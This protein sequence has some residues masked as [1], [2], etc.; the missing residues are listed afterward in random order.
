MHP[1]VEVL[2]KQVDAVHISAALTLRERQAMNI[3]ISNAMKTN[4]VGHVEI[5]WRH[6]MPMRELLARLGENTRN[7]SRTRAT[8]D[9]LVD[10]KIQWAYT[11][12]RSKHH[13]GNTSLLAGYAIDD[14]QLSYS[15]SAVLVDRL[16]QPEVF[17]R[18]NMG[19]QSLFTHFHSLALYENCARYRDLGH[20]AWWS[21]EQFRGL[22]GVGHRTA[23][24][25]FK[26]LNRWVIKPATEDCNRNS[27][28]RVEPEFRRQGRAVVA[29]RFA[30][31]D[32][33]EYTGPRFPS[34]KRLDKLVDDSVVETDPDLFEHLLG[35]G[36]DHSRAADLMSRFDHERIRGNL[37]VV[38]DRYQRSP[39]KITNLASYTVSAIVNDYRPAQVCQQ[40][41]LAFAAQ[42][43]PESQEDPVETAKR[44][45]RDCLLDFESRD[46]PAYLVDQWQASQSSKTLAVERENFYDEVL[47]PNALFAKSYRENPDKK[48][49]N[50][51]WRNWIRSNRISEPTESD[52]QNAAQALGIDLHDLRLRAAL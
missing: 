17:A 13:Y 23:Y 32:N 29:I 43:E 2:N 18:L 44:A 35:F 39:D 51:L 10:K 6:S 14:G 24:L 40:Q 37:R 12:S 26:E 49:L 25:A 33:P 16:L 27:E 42:P 22:M 48:S 20:T 11:D 21:L 1:Q 41:V 52:H 7:Y 9:G 34:S 45:A 3:L 28:I 36:I 30:I 15:Y 4:A 38:A 46:L 47:A 5:D 50:A 31:G 8:L 19:V